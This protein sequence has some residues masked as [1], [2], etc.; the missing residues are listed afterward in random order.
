MPPF[1]CADRRKMLSA[2][3]H[4]LRC[5]NFRR[6]SPQ[7]L[8]LLLLKCP[9]FRCRTVRQELRRRMFCSDP[10]FVRHPPGSPPT[11]RHSPPTMRH[12]L[13]TTRHPPPTMRHPRPLRGI[14]RPLCSILCLLRGILR[15]LCGIPSA[16]AAIFEQK[17][18]KRTT[19]GVIPKIALLRHKSGQRHY[20]NTLGRGSPPCAG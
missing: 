20:A 9:R 2:G 4:I 17:A 5:P 19:A 18:P 6:R 10:S 15:L 8:R 1:F 3:T 16:S 12:S 14:P 7:Q 13:P 11:M